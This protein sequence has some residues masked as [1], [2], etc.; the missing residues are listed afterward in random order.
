MHDVLPRVIGGL[1]CD[2]LTFF[3]NIFEVRCSGSPTT[4]LHRVERTVLVVTGSDSMEGVKV[5]FALC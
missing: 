1:L 5:C 2:Y 3:K 4:C